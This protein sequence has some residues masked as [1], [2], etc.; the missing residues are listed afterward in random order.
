MENLTEK[1][2]KCI[3]YLANEMSKED[4]SVFEIEL[5]IDDELKSLYSYYKKI[6]M[7]YPNKSLELH[8]EISQQKIQGKIREKVFVKRNII[9]VT[10]FIFLML[11]GVSALLFSDTIKYT[12]IKIADKGER[13]HFYLPDSSSVILNAGATL[14]YNQKFSNPRSV[15]LNGE[16]FFEV[17]KDQNNPF[18]VH[19]AEVDVE[20]VGTSF[21]VLASTEKQT[22][23]LET[24]KVN[25]L[26]KRT[27]DRVNLL[28]EEQLIW[29]VS[30]NEV[31]KRNFKPQKFLAW[32]ENTLLLDNLPFSEAIH[33]INEFYGVHFSIDEDRL[34]TQR[35]TGAFK[36][37][38]L[39]DFIASLEFITNVK[40]IKHTAKTFSIQASDEN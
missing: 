8:P 39:E 22:I 9:L 32:K 5:S 7:F 15:F 28:P 23:S 2:K 19:T 34:K 31:I 36:D 16:A 33:K 20:V 10:L 40:V 24:G 3:R 21:G 12:N 14:K 38:S 35:I 18:I 1:D 29:N 6:W 13:L 27:K 4:R 17:T 37:Q 30:S 26:L 25:V 11:S